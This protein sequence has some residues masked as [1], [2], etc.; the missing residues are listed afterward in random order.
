MERLDNRQNE[1][2]RSQPEGQI[3]LEKIDINVVAG[4]GLRRSRRECEEAGTS[5]RFARETLEYCE[6]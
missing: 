1:R 3:T 4:K 6:D 5:L 2:Q